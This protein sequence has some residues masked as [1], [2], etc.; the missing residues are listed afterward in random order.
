MEMEG[1]KNEI[2]KKW[3]KSN[4]KRKVTENEERAERE[5]ERNVLSKYHQHSR[6]FL[7]VVAF[8]PFSIL[9][10]DVRF[11]FELDFLPFPSS[12]FQPAFPSI[13]FSWMM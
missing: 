4:T 8:S 2:R 9:N 11:E 13:L 12:L 5:E 1:G 3:Y 10:N 7:F 6:S